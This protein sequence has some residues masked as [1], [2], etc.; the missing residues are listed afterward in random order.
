LEFQQNFS[1]LANTFRYFV[2][3]VFCGKPLKVKEVTD[4]LRDT[5]NYCAVAALHFGKVTG[6]GCSIE[7]GVLLYVEEA[8]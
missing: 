1:C 5:E 7:N 6:N 4:C 2:H 3:D 8:Y